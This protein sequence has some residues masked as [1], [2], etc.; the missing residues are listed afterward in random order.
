MLGNVGVDFVVGAIPLLGDMFDVVWKANRK[1]ARLLE[2]HL[3]G[4]EGAS[5]RLAELA[6]RLTRFSCITTRFVRF[7]Q[8]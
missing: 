1:N 6:S 4:A 8:H 7:P 5:R 3:H 2:Q